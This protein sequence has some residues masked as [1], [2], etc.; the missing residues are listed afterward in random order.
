MNTYTLEKMKKAVEWFQSRVS[1]AAQAT[2]EIYNAAI[3]ALTFYENFA[4]KSDKD[5]LARKLHEFY[6]NATRELKPESYNKEA[7]KSFDDLTGEQKSIDTS[8]AEQLREYFE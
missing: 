4:E 3:E 1:F 5:I 6:L 8:I 2:I 7:Q